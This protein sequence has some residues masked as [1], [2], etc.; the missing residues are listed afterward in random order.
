MAARPTTV[1]VRRKWDVSSSSVMSSACVS[2]GLIR[3]SLTDE[4]ASLVKLVF[5]GLW[6]GVNWFSSVVAMASAFSELLFFRVLNVVYL[7]KCVFQCCFGRGLASPMRLRALLYQRSRFAV[8]SHGCQLN[9]TNLSGNH[10]SVY[11]LLL[12]CEVVLCLNVERFIDEVLLWRDRNLHCPCLDRQEP[13]LSL[14]GPTGTFTVLAWTDRNLHCPCLDRQGPEKNILKELVTRNLVHGTSSLK[15]P[16]LPRGSS[17]IRTVV[18]F[19]ETS[20]SSQ[21]RTRAPRVSLG[22]RIIGGNTATIEN[23]PYQLSLQLRT[24]NFH[25]CGASIIGHSWAISAV[26]CTRGYMPTL[27]GLRAGSSLQQSG[28]FVHS[29]AQLIEHPLYDDFTNENDIALLRVNE[30]FVFG[31]GVQPVPLAAAGSEVSAGTYAV[32]AGWGETV[33]DGGF[34]SQLRQ[35]SL[36]VVSSVLCNQAYWGAI[37][38]NM[39]CAGYLEGGVASCQGL[40][41]INGLILFKLTI[42]QGDVGGALVVG[43]VQVGVLSWGERCALEGYPGVSTKISHYRGWIQMNTGV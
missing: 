39:I 42:V 23:F 20:D 15:F 12:T 36:P 21:A 38:S 10:P 11:W 18:S 28:G 29:V 5:C 13:S 1:I 41:S 40:T 30:P 24:I 6:L 9:Y 25:I 7:R 31:V 32:A 19:F 2:F 17:A 14:L 26:Q 33:N 16:L 27:L 3:Y 4:G 34:V 8:S 43:G 35:V 22:S 37:T